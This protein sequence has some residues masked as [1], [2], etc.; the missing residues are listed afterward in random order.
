MPII[1]REKTNAK[2]RELTYHSPALSPADLGVKL[3]RPMVGGFAHTCNRQ[4]IIIPRRSM[5]RHYKECEDE[6]LVDFAQEGDEDA[7][8]ELKRRHWDDLCNW[9]KPDYWDYEEVAQEAFVNAWLGIKNFKKKSSFKT[10]LFRIARNKCLNAIRDEENERRGWRLIEDIDPNIAS[11]APRPDETVLIEEIA[12][13]LHEAIYKLPL[14]QRQ[15]IIFF[16]FEGLKVR[17]IAEQLDRP[18]ST[19]KTRL[20]RARKELGRALRN[21][22]GEG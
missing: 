15:C 8:G 13:I 16:Y 18:V 9:C 22:L 4:L 12:R 10:W 11:N 17:Q 1:E 5:M 21:I 19:I 14:D 3:T 20:F 2:R 6:E 7:F